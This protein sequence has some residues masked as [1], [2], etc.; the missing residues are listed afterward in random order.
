MI[1]VISKRLCKWQCLH[2]KSSL[3]RARP[4]SWVE[5]HVNFLSVTV[6]SSSIKP[7]T[8]SFSSVLFIAMVRPYFA[9]D[10]TTKFPFPWYPR[11][12]QEPP[13][14]PSDCSFKKFCRDFSARCG[15]TQESFDRSQQSQ[16]HVCLTRDFIPVGC[17]LAPLMHLRHCNEKVQQPRP[18]CFVHAWQAE[19]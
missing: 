14:H 15:S 16:M 9:D 17:L 7:W 18:N 10:W 3:N 13:P 1:N 19:F 6:Q 5:L 2:P 11:S 4:L 12:E 8:I